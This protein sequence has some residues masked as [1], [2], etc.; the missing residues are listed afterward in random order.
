MFFVTCLKHKLETTKSYETLLYF[1][2]ETL[3]TSVNQIGA[4]VKYEGSQY[5]KYNRGQKGGTYY[6]CLALDNSRANPL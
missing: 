6:F 3:D 4:I 1:S 2:T 5:E